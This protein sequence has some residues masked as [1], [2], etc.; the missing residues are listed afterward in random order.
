MS[1]GLLNHEADMII[2]SKSGYVTEIEIKRSL[3]D[4]KADFRKKHDH[5]DKLV[6]QLYYAVPA[7]IYEKCMELL[8]GNKREAGILTYNEK[9]SVSYAITAPTLHS[10][11]R[12]LFLEEQFQLARLGSMRA[13]ALKEKLYGNKLFD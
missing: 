6:S 2:M 1:W 13:W 8:K 7:C 5:S 12:K 10:N 11:R 4:F 3:S 9:G